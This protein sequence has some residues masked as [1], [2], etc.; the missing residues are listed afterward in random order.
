MLDYSENTE[1][2]PW[3]SVQIVHVYTLIH[4]KI[5]NK[6]IQFILTMLKHLAILTE[7]Y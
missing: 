5:F 7:Q 1:D 2:I 4:R 3:K 6:Y